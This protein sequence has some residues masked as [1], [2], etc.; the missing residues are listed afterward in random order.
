MNF[1]KN[2]LILY[3]CFWNDNLSRFFF[4]IKAVD[5]FTSEVFHFWVDYLHAGR[6]FSTWINVTPFYFYWLTNCTQACLLDR[7]TCTKNFNPIRTR[8]HECFHF[9]NERPSSTS[10]FT[11][12]RRRFQTCCREFRTTN[13]H[14]GLRGLWL[15]LYGHVSRSIRVGQGVW[16]HCI[17]T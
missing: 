7:Q 14:N 3:S 2:H 6:I 15:S 13:I 8:H 10:V 17:P 12:C 1:I 11:R 5:V 16:W 9:F 4:L